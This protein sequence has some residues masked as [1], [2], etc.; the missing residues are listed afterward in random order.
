LIESHIDKALK[1]A[2]EAV[3]R[4]RSQF[5]G[6]GRFHSG[7]RIIHSIETAKR[8]F[9]AG[10]DAVLVELERTIHKTQLNPKD[11]RQQTEQNLLAFA[12]QA[13]GAAQVSDAGGFDFNVTERLA[14]FDRY[15]AFA[16]K[17][18]DVGL[19]NRPEPETPPMANAIN[20]GTMTGS[21]IQQSSPGATQTVELKIDV[22]AVTAALST[23]ESELSRTKI[24]ENAMAS[25]LADIATIKA[26]LSK[27]SP[28]VGILQEA[29]RSVRNVI[30]GIAAG[31][32]TPEAIAAMTALGASL[33]LI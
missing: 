26:Q 14:A 5:N 23:L 17:Q 21:V 32:L 18:F 30:E 7:G 9:E 31:M 33:G 13:K 3:N 12:E 20:I 11:L 6:A 27:P 24:D 19:F 8:E 15:V 29:G 10:V 25:L 28:S 16:L 22:Q 1:A 4:V 2:V